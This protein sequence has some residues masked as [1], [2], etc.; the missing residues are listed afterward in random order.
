M[1]NRK[2]VMA[3]AAVCFGILV[4]IGIYYVWPNGHWLGYVA[5]ALV[6]AGAFKTWPDLTS[7]GKI[8]GGT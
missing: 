2:Q 7:Q 5:I 3:L 4:A 1:L 6:A 8:L